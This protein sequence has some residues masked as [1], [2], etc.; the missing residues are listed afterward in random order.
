MVIHIIID[1]AE[2]KLRRLI[3]R[4]A[5]K[6]ED[7]MDNL[8]KDLHNVDEHVNFVQ[9]GGMDIRTMQKS[10]IDLTQTVMSE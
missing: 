6:L 2:D 3:E 8:N 10:E 7:K 9:R 5:R 1:A 4:I